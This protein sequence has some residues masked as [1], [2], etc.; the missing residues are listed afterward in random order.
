VHGLSEC[1]N[2]GVIG[3]KVTAEPLEPLGMFLVVRVSDGLEEVVVSPGA[4]DILGWTAS[5]CFDQAGIGHARDGISDA[6]DAD[7][8]L[9]AVAEVVEIFERSRAFSCVLES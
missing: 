6:L 9:P 1:L 5:G 2:I 3:I 8:M 4:A 7:R